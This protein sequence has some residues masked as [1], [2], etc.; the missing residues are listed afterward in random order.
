MVLL[1][2][3]IQNRPSVSMQ[4]G[5]FKQN[6]KTKLLIGM[7][8][9]VVKT[10]LTI[11]MFMANKCIKCIATDTLFA[12]TFEGLCQVM[13]VTL[14]KPLFVDFFY[15]FVLFPDLKLGEYNKYFTFITRLF[16]EFFDMLL[17]YQMQPNINIFLAQ[18]AWIYYIS[19]IGKYHI[20]NSTFLK[21]CGIGSHVI[22]ISF[23]QHDVLKIDNNFEILGFN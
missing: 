10:S 4:I 11:L 13:I 2:S 23:L 12:T 20:L 15:N 5:L 22:F 9:V 6:L 18:A 14:L 17:M 19:H 1:I 21:V 3:N 8:V 7:I 16:F